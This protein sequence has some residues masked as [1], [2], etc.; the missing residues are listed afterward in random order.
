MDLIPPELIVARYFSEEN[1]EIERMMQQQEDASREIEEFVEENTGEE[2]LLEEAVNEKGSVTKSAVT[3]RLKEL[4]RNPDPEFE[5]E[6]KALSRYLELYEAESAA[7]KAIKD[8]QS[9]LDKKVLQKY[10]ELTEEDIKRLVVN[11]KWFRKIRTFIE[12]EVE[13]LTQGLSN[14]IKELEERYSQTLPDI[15]KE[16]DQFSKKVAEH[17]KKMGLVW[18]E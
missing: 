1:A 16:V 5:D 18:N 3:D 7:K 4:G 8:A 2:G 12:E 13:K 15:E 11:D 6:H 9:V 10:G 17:L 14:R